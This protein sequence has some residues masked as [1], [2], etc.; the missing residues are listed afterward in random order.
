MSSPP[1]LADAA[2][3]RLLQQLSALE[4]AGVAPLQALDA[5]QG[6]GHLRERLLRTRGWLQ[7][8]HSLSAAGRLGGLFSEVEA[9]VIGAATQA[10]TPAE[11]LRKL[12]DR[13]SAAAR[14]G[15]QVRAR[16]LL[17]AAVGLIAL[18]VMPLPVL[19]AGSLS[20]VRYL[21]GVALPVAAVM[22]LVALGRELRR[23][24]AAAA[25]WPGRELAEVL[26]LRLPVFGDLIARTQ[27]QRF[28]DHMGVLLGAGLP[29]VEAVRVAAGTLQ[30]LRVR[31]DFESV[32]PALSAGASLQQ[33]AEH[34]SLVDDS[35]LPGLIAAG[36]GSGRLP[37][38]LQRY[39]SEE[40]AAIEAR[41]ESLATW[42]P[43]LV[44]AAL[45]LWLAASLIGGFSALLERRID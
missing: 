13:A 7:H 18:V 40:A 5:L 31:E 19:V 9:A 8:G 6:E 4:R 20:P 33:A 16:L 10:G 38:L 22:A 24:D 32:L 15:A 14:R 35:R 37:E 12:G 41:V 34:W 30:M 36:E 21:A 45:A 2:R 29:A 23:R 17:P 27:V 11:A 25:Q 28:V 43:R 1:L 39:A 44:Y 42:L 26:L 3:A